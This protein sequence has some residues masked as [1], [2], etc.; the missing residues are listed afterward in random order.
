MVRDEVEG[1]RLKGATHSVDIVQNVT[2]L[3]GK[4]LRR[5]LRDEEETSREQS[6]D[7]DL[8]LMGGVLDGD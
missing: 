5:G 2:M 3:C 6:L 7:E 4:D 1:R 8:K